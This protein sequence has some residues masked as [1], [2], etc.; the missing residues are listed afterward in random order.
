MSFGGGWSTC[1]CV[2]GLCFHFWWPAIAPGLLNSMPHTLH[3]YCGLGAACTVPPNRSRISDGSSST[4]IAAASN[5]RPSLFAT[6]AL[7][8][9]LNS[10]IRGPIILRMSPDLRAAVFTR[11]EVAVWGLESR[12]AAALVQT[13]LRSGT[14]AWCGARVGRTQ[15]VFGL[16]W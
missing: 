14:K 8:M 5:G 11:E 16:C 9:L 13:D 15:R 12:C 6:V 10:T 3:W 2:S 4:T 1:G 7:S